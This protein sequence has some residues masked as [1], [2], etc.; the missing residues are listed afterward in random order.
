MNRFWNFSLSIFRLLSAAVTE[1][2][3]S[4]S[5]CVCVGGTSV[6]ILMSVLLNLLNFN[7]FLILIPWDKDKVTV[8][9]WLP[10]FHTKVLYIKCILFV[11]SN[12]NSNLENN[13]LLT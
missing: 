2:L 6:D 7:P 8:F 9:S 5:V 12:H 13:Y 10:S 4:K 1:T 3:E 11:N